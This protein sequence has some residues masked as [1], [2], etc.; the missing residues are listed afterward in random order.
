MTKHQLIEDN[1]NLVYFVIRRYYPKH[2]TNED[3]IQ[4]GMVGL[5]KA[6]EKYE[7][8]KGQFSTYAT[9]CIRTEICQEFRR[10]SKR[11]DT[12]SLNYEYG[13]KYIGKDDESIALQ[14]ILVGDT[15]VDY[16]DYKYF[17][18]KLTPLQQKIFE[19]KQYGL[20]NAEVGREIG[21]CREYIGQQM[22]LIAHKWTK[23]MENQ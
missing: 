5:C 18:S 9:K 8:D 10:W 13:G 15:D 3:I 23:Y 14:N 7:P 20:N 11:V 12:L 17:Y 1:M 2:I 19:L 21:Y 6:A 4:L 16:V 22:R